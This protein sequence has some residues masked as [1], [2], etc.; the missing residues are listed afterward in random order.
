MLFADRLPPKMQPLSI[1]CLTVVTIT[2][3]SV[4]LVAAKTQL[5]AESIPKYVDDLPIPP[6]LHDV[7]VNNTVAISMRQ[8]SQ[9]VLPGAYPETTLWAYGNPDDPSSFSHPSGTI[10]NVENEVMTVIW[11]N[12]LVENPEQCRQNPNSEACNYIKHVLQD[13]FG[14][15]LVDQTLHWAAPNQQ[16]DDGKPRTDCHGNTVEP[17]NGPIPITSHVHGA[18]HASNSD[19]YPESWFLPAANNIPEGYATKG[20]YYTSYINPAGIEENVTSVDN[21]VGYAVYKYNNTEANAIL[22]YHDHTLGITR[23]NVYAAGAGFWLV[24]TKTEADSFIGKDCEGNDQVLPGPPSVYGE[25]PNGDP[26]V[27]SKIREIPIAIQPMTFYDD[28][29]LFFPANRLFASECG[30]GRVFGNTLDVDVPFKP[31]PNSDISPIWSPET[32]F[33]TIVVNGKTWPKLEVAPERYRFR[34]LNVADSNFLNLA[35]ITEDN[36]ELPMYVIGADQGFLPNVV[37]IRTGFFTKIMPCD[38]ETSIEE[39][40]TSSMLALLMGPGERYDVIIDFTGIP[41]GNEIIMRNTAPDEPFKHFDSEDLVKEKH[42]IPADSRTTGQVMK[43]IVKEELMNP[44]GDR[45]TPPDQLHL[46]T[47]PL[48]PNATITRDLAILEVESQICVKGEHCAIS[49]TECNGENSFGPIRAMLGYDGAKGPSDA[50]GVM[51]MDAMFLNPSVGDTEVWVSQ[52]R[53]SFLPNLD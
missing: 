30:G 51:W 27:R 40:Q 31:D 2:L 46:K 47:A 12:E 33:Q 3:C 32:F 18:R 45:S 10:E 11:M 48:P 21:S 41:D 52:Y 16:C 15:P 50:V 38:N 35:L 4:P 34:I 9:Q 28:G 1:F 24:R 14:A 13:M 29:S 53:T 6:V 19:G 42:Y 26:S 8:I 39:P 36:E 37:K 25:D 23:L 20:T 22:W 44:D 7:K 5:D 17:Y 49:E 43:F